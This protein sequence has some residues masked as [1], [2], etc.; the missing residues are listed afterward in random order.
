MTRAWVVIVLWIIFGS[1]YV[2][3]VVSRVQRGRGRGAGPWH[4]WGN[5]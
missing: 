2:L 1:L 3:D 5:W 4:D